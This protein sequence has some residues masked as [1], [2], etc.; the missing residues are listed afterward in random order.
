MLILNTGG[1]FNK[2]YNPISGKLEVPYDNLAVETVLESLHPKSTSSLTLTAHVKDQPLAG[3]VYKDSLDITADDRKMIASIILQSTEKVFV[4]VHGTDTMHLSA[5][6]LDALVED[7][8]VIFT[9]AM[10]PFHID[11][12]EATANLAMAIGFAKSNPPKGAY[13]CMS[14]EVLPHDQIQK[15]RALGVFE[16]V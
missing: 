4:V 12:V 1:T 10:V 2:R 15:N 14:G 3:T 7:Q 11:P 8:A 6:L 5:A 13:I 9:G 16:R